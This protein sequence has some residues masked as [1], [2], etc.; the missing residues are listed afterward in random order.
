M[1]RNASVAQNQR[2][3][4]SLLASAVQKGK[5]RVNDTEKML[6]AEACRHLVHRY[7]Y[8]NDERDFAG[9]AAMFTED[10][11]L[12]RPSAPDKPIQ[13][14]AAILAA[15]QTRP[16]T[17]AT[18]HVCTDVVVEVLSVNHAT[19]RSRILMLSGERTAGA[20][21]PDAATV[22]APLPGTF[23]DELVLTAEGWR[24]ASRKGGLWVRPVDAG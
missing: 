8:L 7:A 2:S 3:C 6:V 9:I 11:L 20:T 4:E 13:G 5:N 24:F 10:G 12:F 16:A 19:A 22:K 1:E 14:R 17:T 18:F 21:V 23:E 15:L